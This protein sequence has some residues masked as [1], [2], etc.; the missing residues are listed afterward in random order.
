MTPEQI[1]KGLTNGAVKACVNMTAEYQFPG[2]K[3]FNANGAFALYWARDVGGRGSVCE[4]ENLPFGK[5]K[6]AAYRLTPLGLEV[7]AI[8]E[9][10]P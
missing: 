7:R 6:R 3:T 8:L 5:Y 4:R 9:Q 10:Q 2:D 1:A